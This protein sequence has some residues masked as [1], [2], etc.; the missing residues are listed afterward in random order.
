LQLFCHASLLQ[1]IE[2][3]GISGVVLPLI[4]GTASMRAT[5]GGKLRIKAAE[6]SRLEELKEREGSRAV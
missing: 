6:A 4:T 2:I 1:P 3:K 5:L